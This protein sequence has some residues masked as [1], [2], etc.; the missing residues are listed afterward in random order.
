[1]QL[2]KNQ[3]DDKTK[4][5]VRLH[6]ANKCVL[7]KENWDLHLESFRPNQKKNE[8]RAPTF[9]ER[10]IEWTSSIEEKTWKAAVDSTQERVQ[11]FRF[12]F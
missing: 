8:I 3:S 2:R 6:L 10:S 4:Y 12:I 11:S 7:K 1:M 5:R 9:E